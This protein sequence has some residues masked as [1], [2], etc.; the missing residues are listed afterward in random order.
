M[1]KARVA[2]KHYGQLPEPSEGVKFLAYTEEFLQ[3]SVKTFFQRDFDSISLAELIEDGDV[4]GKLLAAQVSLTEGKLQDCISHC[5]EAE[6]LVSRPISMLFPSVATGI[7]DFARL[8]SGPEQHEVRKL[9]SYFKDYLEA[10]RNT[11]L[12]ALL[13]AY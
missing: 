6:Y 1:N 10:L 7:T 9:L 5:A 13:G 8:V 4:R 11:S 12:A 3:E 2:F